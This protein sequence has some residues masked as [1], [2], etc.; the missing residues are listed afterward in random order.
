MADGTDPIAAASDSLPPT[1]PPAQVTPAQA[2]AQFPYPQETPTP[3]PA[4]QQ[5]PQ[6][7]PTQAPAAAAVEQHMGWLGRALDAVATALA[8][9]TSYQVTRNTD[10]TVSAQPMPSTE[11]DKWGKIA[12]AA[13]GGAATGIGQGQGINALPRAAAAG[14]GFGSQIPAQ[15][16]SQAEQAADFQNKQLIQ[17]ANNALLDQKIIQERFQNQIEPELW[18]EHMTDH[19]LDTESKLENLGAIYHGEFNNA[20]ELADYGAANQG[21][22]DAHTGKYGSVL[23]PIPRPDGKVA[24]YEIP[25]DTAK[26]RTTEDHVLDRWGLAADGSGDITHTPV[27]MLAGSGTNG[28]WATAVKANIDANNKT[29]VSSSTIKKNAGSGSEP[30]TEAQAI[31]DK[32]NQQYPNDPH[33]ALAGAT[34]EMQQNRLQASAARNQPFTAPAA[35]TAAAANYN[36]TLED[37]LSG[38][39]LLT[40]VPNYSRPGQPNRAT[41]EADAQRLAASR[42]QVFNP[43][44][45]EQESKYANLPAVQSAY[46]AFNRMANTGGLLDQLEAQ[47]RRA[48]I[49][50]TNAPLNNVIQTLE[51]KYGEGESNALT[52]DLAEVQQNLAAVLGTPGLTGS[53]T[54]VKLDHWR[55]AYGSNLTLG[56]LAAMNREVRTSINNER[57]IGINNNRFLR[58]QFG[59]A[60]PQQ[61]QQQQ[62]QQPQ[63]GGLPNS[64]YSRTASDGKGNWQGLFGTQWK[65]IAPPAGR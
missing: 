15:Q 6:Q 26:Q 22:V 32:W 24:V 7:A 18:N 13:L 23:L 60:Q 62:P 4:P 38:R 1:A 2:A 43:H 29:A 10:G 46:M 20:A 57:Q 25:A 21:A 48:G 31:I 41:V 8:G 19:M 55:D 54:N 45:I 52:N 63:G 37:L 51:R 50:D 17:R 14:F 28:D 44:A 33:S 35:G 11:G 47:V 36:Q 39:T 27:T 49:T 59:P 3:V 5:P 40:D 34:R 12:A 61:Q 58:Q 65:P 56:S 53:L 30:K 42:G 64:G 9:P 16:Q